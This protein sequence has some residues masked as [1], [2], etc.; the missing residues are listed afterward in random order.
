MNWPQNRW[1]IIPPLAAVAVLLTLAFSF[2]APEGCGGSPG[3]KVSQ[4]TARS[5]ALTSVQTI[6]ACAS[7]YESEFRSAAL[8]PVNNADEIALCQT[9]SDQRDQLIA[10]DDPDSRFGITE[11]LEQI[12]VQIYQTAGNDEHITSLM[13]KQ[14]GE[15]CSV[16]HAFAGNPTILPQY[17]NMEEMLI[18]N[19]FCRKNSDGT[20][21][22]AIG[23]TCTS[24]PLTQIQG[25]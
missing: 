24:C 18:A 20:F 5:S 22:H 1:R 15:T 4:T 6:G 23:F 7:Q 21:F 3:E 8:D 14:A 11:Y 12:G 17:K 2:G 19:R 16:T 13:V 9:F 25:P 10:T